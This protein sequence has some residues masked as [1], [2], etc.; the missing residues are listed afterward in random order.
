MKK[1]TLAELLET[2]LGSVMELPLG[3]VVRKGISED[4][5]FKLSSE[6]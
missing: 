1:T 6:W 2:G 3:P 4:T 5:T